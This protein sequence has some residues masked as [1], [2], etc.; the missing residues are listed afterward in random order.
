MINHI[1]S[2]IIGIILARILIPEDFG[3]VGMVVI[4]VAVSQTLI[5]SGFGQALIR[6]KDATDIDY[7]T[8]FYFNILVGF[9]LY[10]IVFFS[11]SS[12]SRFYDEPA[13]IP[14]LKVFGLNIVIN[15]ISVI[16]RIKL[17]KQVNFKLQTKITLFSS[18]FSGA[19]GI[20]MAYRGFG[21]WSLVWRNIINNT[22][23]TILLW[24]YNRWVPLIVFSIK[25]FTEMFAFGSRLLVIGLL[26]TF[27]KNIYLIVIGKFFSSS[28]LGYYTRA[29]QFSKLPSQNITNVIQK[30]SYPVLVTFQDDN[31]K[32]K[33]AYKR[34]IKNTMYISFVLMMLLAAIAKPMIIILIGEKW[35]QSVV[36][37]QLLCFGGMLY[38]LHALN[39]N[40]LNVKG[41]S[42][43]FLRLAVIQKLLAI[44][45]IVFGVLT[46]IEVLIIG[47]VL[48]SF[49]AFFI[50]SFFSGR[51]IGYSV[52]EQILDIGPSFILGFS[53]ALVIY[54]PTLFFNIPPMPLLSGQITIA[55]GLVILLSEV[56]RMNSYLEMK[57]IV[58]EKIR[59]VITRRR[60]NL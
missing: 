24:I 11:A 38:P 58:S 32:L 59:Q 29:D 3:L 26:D 51:L 34:L 15:S 57:T 50:N 39:L 30:V 9:G 56:F 22:L 40:M 17:I 36:Y 52:R 20:A 1:L 2:F 46:G 27:Y 44:P 7:S 43:L 31:K 19:I 10:A 55:F 4:F 37:L 54:L 33:D 35:M 60:V 16:Q 8:V 45:I 47:M 13:L 53:V 6:K 41:R 12:I 5:D 42:D 18:I 25:S 49:V 21:V 48:L 14:I 28:E 23:Q